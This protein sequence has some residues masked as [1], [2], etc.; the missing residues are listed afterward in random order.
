MMVISIL[1][2]A[3]GLSFAVEWMTG[4]GAVAALAPVVGFAALI[5]WSSPGDRLLVLMLVVA[6]A[7][8]GG[9][10]GVFAARAL[11]RRRDARNVL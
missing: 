11:K 10:W 4:R 3:F 7:A 2:V 5:L 6:L 1:A 9:G 8:F